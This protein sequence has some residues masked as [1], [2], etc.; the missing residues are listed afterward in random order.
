MTPSNSNQLSLQAQSLNRA[1]NKVV[2]AVS[3]YFAPLHIGHLELFKA[4]RILGDILVVIVNNDRQTRLK[5]SVPFMAE[6]E[7]LEIVRA[8]RYVDQAILAMDEDRS[9]N[10]TLEFIKP[11]I[12]ANGGDV[13]QADCRETDTCVK[14]GIQM[15]F[16]IGGNKV[17]SSSA[18]IAQART[19]QR[20]CQ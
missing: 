17:Q 9:V 13:H 5:G 10:V 19:Q 7:R 20:D 6:D 18:L 1:T 16:G 3:G 4:A 2:V 11:T 14:F 12:F 15:A 8:I